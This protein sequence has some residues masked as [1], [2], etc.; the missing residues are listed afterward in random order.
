MHIS[1]VNLSSKQWLAPKQGNGVE[2]PGFRIKL[3][4]SFL[5]F[6]QIE[7]IISTT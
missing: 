7:I 1:H 4:N 6:S 3:R 5:W 2:T